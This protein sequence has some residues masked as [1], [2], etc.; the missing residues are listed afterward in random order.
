V[1]ITDT[2]DNSIA[3]LIE[4]LV[5]ADSDEAARIRSRIAE[6]ESMKEQYAT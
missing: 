3:E 4:Q 6:L 2:I 5:D 1:A